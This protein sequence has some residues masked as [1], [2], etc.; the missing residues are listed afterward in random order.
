MS[1]RVLKLFLNVLCRQQG[2]LCNNQCSCD[3]LERQ[4]RRLWEPPVRGEVQ[5]G[6]KGEEFP[7]N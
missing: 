2:P 4:P 5:A 3:A 1:I 6:R 7:E